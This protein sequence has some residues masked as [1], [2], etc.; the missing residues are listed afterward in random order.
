MSLVKVQDHP[1]LLKDTESKA[2]LNTN[3]AS[4]L[5]YKKKQQ[6]LKDM[7]SLKTEVVELKQM[8]SQI[9]TILNK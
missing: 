6:M 4:L 3:Y 8:M 2:V 1:D 9:L 5:E 7:D